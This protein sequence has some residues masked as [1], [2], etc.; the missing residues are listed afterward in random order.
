MQID[1]SVLP[2]DLFSQFK[3]TRPDR[4]HGLLNLALDLDTKR[5]DLLFE[6]ANHLS[7]SY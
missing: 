7:K 3:V 5:Q 2:L 4:P 1:L 6:P